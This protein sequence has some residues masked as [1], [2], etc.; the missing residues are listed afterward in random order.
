MPTTSNAGPEASL[1]GRLRAILG[2]APREPV[3]LAPSARR[4]R[5]RL[6]QHVRAGVLV[7]LCLQVGLGLPA[8]LAP[9]RMILAIIASAIF[10]A[11]TGYLVSS[12]HWG[13]LGGALFSSAMFTVAGCL[14]QIPFLC[15]GGSLV[16]LASGSLIW[17]LCIGALPG[18]LIGCHVRVDS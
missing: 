11:P 5:Q 13:P 18:L 6:R 7:F 14:S 3:E 4:H 12:R 16:A 17:G 15:G 8:S 1:L 9:G 10:G 2:N